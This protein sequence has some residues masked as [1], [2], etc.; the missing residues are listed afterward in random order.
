MEG[1]EAVMQTFRFHLPTEVLASE[2]AVAH[3]ADAWVNLGEKVL[4]VTGKSGAERSGALADVKRVLDTHGRAW[5]HFDGIHANPDADQVYAG[6]ELARREQCDAV[7]AIGGGSALDAAKAIAWVVA[8]GIPRERFFTSTPGDEPSA[9]LPIVAIPLTCG[10]GS[11]VTPYSIITDHEAQTKVNLC[12]N[13]LFP[14][15]ALLDARYL[16][17]L[18]EC[19]VC[20]TVLDALS[21][22]IEGAYSL[23]ANALSLALSEEAV[24]VLIPELSRWVQGEKPGLSRLF[25]ASMVAGMVIAQ[26]GTGLVHAMGYPLTYHCGIP[27]G[28]AN[29]A[30]LAGYM[31]F[32]L[33]SCRK[34]TIQ[35]L[36][37][38]G[39]NAPEDLQELVDALMDKMGYERH[40]PSEEDLVRFAREPLRLSVVRRYRTMPSPEE[41]IDLY[42]MGF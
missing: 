22:A 37:A 25:Y 13:A 10:T 7:V 16:E 38:G 27:H 1:E 30:L 21:H 33:R 31:T 18:P 14:K 35:L 9:A 6:A 23:R 32:M 2:N 3:F 19:V 29:G 39:M 24:R 17:S 15:V 42:R 40:A 20:D 4:L 34:T 28:R 11:E 26:T 12:G 36:R 41:V 8:S 5:A